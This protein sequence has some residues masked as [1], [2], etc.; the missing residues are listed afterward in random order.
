[1]EKITKEECP[2]KKGSILWRGWDVPPFFGWVYQQGEP[3]EC[4]DGTLLVPV[5][6]QNFEHGL[7][8]VYL[9]LGQNGV[10]KF[11]H[12]VIRMKD[13]SADTT[14]RHS[15]G[16][17]RVISV[18]PDEYRISINDVLFSISRDERGE[19]VGYARIVGRG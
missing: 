19:G 11:R 13:T 2:L 14:I 15:L 10:L 18:T 12:R 6:F 3:Y 8:S 16:F 17:P 5:R 1:M 4:D 9:E 7:V